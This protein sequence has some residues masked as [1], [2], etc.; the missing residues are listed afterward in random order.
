DSAP[1]HRRGA[2]ADRQRD[3]LWRDD[4]EARDGHR[5]GGRWRRGGWDPR[6]AHPPCRPARIVHRAWRWNHDHGG[7]RFL[8]LFAIAA[9]AALFICTASRPASAALTLCNQTSY[10]V[11][12][13]IG[14]AT[15]KELDTRGWTRVA[16]GDCQNPI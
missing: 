9:L 14:S 16:P 12:A 15:K 11:Y 4:S 6:W 13:A 7:M 5:S 1:Q 3:D 8:R 2:C 10:I